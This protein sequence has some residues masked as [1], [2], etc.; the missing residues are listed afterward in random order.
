MTTLGPQEESGRL[1]MRKPTPFS[2]AMQR[3][4]QHWPKPHSP[5]LSRVSRDDT[6]KE[7][8]TP[9]ALCV[10]HSRL[11]RVFTERLVRQGGSSKMMPP[12]GMQR[13][14]TPLSSHQHDIG[15]GFRLEHTT[16]YT[17]PAWPSDITERLHRSGT[18]AATPQT[19][20][21][22]LHL[23]CHST[24]THRAASTRAAQHHAILHNCT[25]LAP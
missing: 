25:T 14:R 3:I 11:D 20:P 8:K 5:E 9:K 21:A 18:S 23:L 16:H 1:D 4:Y 13:P 17:H 19:T 2:H 6:S 15:K 10:A 24:R 22:K 7:G 12:A